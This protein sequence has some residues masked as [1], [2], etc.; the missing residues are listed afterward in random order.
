[1]VATLAMSAVVSTGL[2][3][4]ASSA[5]T[6]STAFSMPRLSRSGSRRRHRAQPLVHERLRQHR[7][8]GGAVTGDVVGLGGDL[9]GELSA[10]VLE[11][12]GELDLLGDGHA[13]VGDGRGAPLLVEHDVAALGAERH[14]HGVGEGV[15]ATLKRAPCLL[16]ELQSLTHE[17]SYRWFAVVTW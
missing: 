2:A 8:G 7:R 9:L 10:Q 5:S 11:R 13:V 6:A 1:M 14:L 3:T 16:V 17:C 12:I 15:D 4:S